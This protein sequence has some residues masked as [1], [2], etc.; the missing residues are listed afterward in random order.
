MQ[1][2]QMEKI[3]EFFGEVR[4]FIQLTCMMFPAQLYTPVLWIKGFWIRRN[5]ADAD[6]P[7]GD[8]CYTSVESPCEK[9]KWS[10][11]IKPCPFF[12]YNQFAKS[13]SYGYCHLLEAGDWQYKGTSLLWDQCKECGVNY[14]DDE[15]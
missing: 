4:W 14:G 11:K 12:D 2:V 9:N 5:L 8:Y 15:C 6:I 3:K 7:L 13:Q 1:G 10:R